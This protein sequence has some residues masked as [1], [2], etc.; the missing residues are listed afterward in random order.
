M[1]PFSLSRR[2]MLKTAAVSLALPRLEAMLDGN[3]LAYANG[4]KLPKRYGL[5]YW[6][7]GNDPARWTPNKTG[8]DYDL[9]EQLAPFQPVREYL[10]VVTGMVCQPPPDGGQVHVGGS[11]SILTGARTNVNGFEQATATQASFDQLLATHLGA[12]SKLK[13][14][15]VRSTNWLHLPAQGGTVIDWASHNGPGAPNKS[16]FNPAVVFDRL[17]AGVTDPNAGAAELERIRK[18]RKSVLDLVMK[19]ADRLKKRVG[20]TDR[21]R[22]DLHLDSIRSIE[23]QIDAMPQMPP[24]SCK[25]PAKPSNPSENAIRARNKIMADLLT[26]AFA[27]DLTRV[28]TLQFSGGGT[29]SEFPDVGVNLDVHEVGHMQGVTAELNKAY[30]FWMESFAVWLSALKATPEG[31]GNL[32]DNCAVFG[33]SDHGYAPSH[34]YD[35]FPLLLAG[36]AQGALKSGIHVRKPDGIATRVPLTIMRALGMT[37]PSWGKESL[38]VSESVSELLA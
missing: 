7:L 8:P 33:T 13:T 29:H 11:A 14:I 38:M 5:F 21:A 37:M 4:D 31:A 18:A 34:K 23:K 12:G 16:E 32:L 35:E 2:T 1:R 25:P 19:D 20:G 24:S 3:G 36:R 6:G 17:F 15:E 26:M 22:L 10:S 28:A 9:K 27:C 30:V